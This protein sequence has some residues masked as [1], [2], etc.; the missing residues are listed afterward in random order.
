MPSLNLVQKKRKETKRKGKENHEV[1]LK[2]A[3]IKS[4]SLIIAFA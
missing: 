2:D 3:L 1:I 4:G